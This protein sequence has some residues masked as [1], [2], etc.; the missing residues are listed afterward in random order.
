MHEDASDK[1]RIEIDP[2]LLTD[3]RVKVTQVERRRLDGEIVIMGPSGLAFDSLQM[4]LHPAESRVC[5]LSAEIPASFV[6]FDILAESEEDLR[7][8]PLS[9]PRLRLD[10]PGDR[11]LTGKGP[12]CPVAGRNP[13]GP[14]TP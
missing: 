9:P 10:L 13:D 3:G 5:R 14:W 2:A 12:F 6:A 11:V 8:S 1:A 7:P 4:R